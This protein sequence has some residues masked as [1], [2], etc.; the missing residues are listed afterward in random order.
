MRSIQKTY[1][2]ASERYPVCSR[3]GRDVQMQRAV[4]RSG[5]APRTPSIW[6]HDPN[7]AN[8]VTENYRP[9]DWSKS[10]MKRSQRHGM[11]EIPSFLTASSA[12][13]VRRC[14]SSDDLLE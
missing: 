12:G 7:R 14:R 4:G 8:N 3:S 2:A 1:W 13:K 10:R 11:N 5:S 6:D 9:P